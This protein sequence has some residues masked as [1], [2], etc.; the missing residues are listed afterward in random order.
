MHLSFNVLHFPFRSP[1]CNVS[2]GGRKSGS[3]LGRRLPGW[4]GFVQGKR[5]AE[6]ERRSV[7]F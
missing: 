6:T 3:K 7:P 4:A 1:N 5:A 2:K